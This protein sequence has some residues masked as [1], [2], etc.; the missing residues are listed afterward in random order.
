M[1]DQMRPTTIASHMTPLRQDTVMHHPSG[2]GGGSFK[3]PTPLLSVKTFRSNA[4]WAYLRGV[5][6]TN[7]VIVILMKCLF[8]VV[9]GVSNEASWTMT[10]VCYNLVSTLAKLHFTFAILVAF[11]FI[12]CRVHFSSCIGSLEAR[13]VLK[14]Q[15]AVNTLAL[16]FGSK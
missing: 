8:S 4:S 7:L 14:R 13:Y 5:W 9:P 12:Y 15:K 11:V 2:I 3:S 1:K 16:P 10:N 6:S